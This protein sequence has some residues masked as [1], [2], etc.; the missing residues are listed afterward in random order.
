MVN[1]KI[2]SS[3]KYANGCHALVLKDISG[4]ELTLELV[5]SILSDWYSGSSSQ[6]RGKVAILKHIWYE[7]Y[8]VTKQSYSDIEWAVFSHK[9]PRN[10]KV[11]V[12][13]YLNDSDVLK[14]IGA[15]R[16]DRQRLFISFLAATGLRISEM[17][18]IRLNQTRNTYKGLEIVIQAEKTGITI[19]R[20]ITEDMARE[21]R[22]I[23]SGKEYLFETSN[24]KPYGREYVSAQ[25]K[26]I[27]RLAIGESISPHS[28]R[29]YWTRK[30]N[31]EGYNSFEIARMMGHK[32]AGSHVDNY[33][34]EVREA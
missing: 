8:G 24:G 9:T 17:T 31:N 28:F 1:L 30:K 7:K 22:S 4:R 10:A 16:S 21:I 14:I 29:H 23:F 20:V 26:K 19:T 34:H 27:G 12:P 3:R 33:L 25:I 11:K 13:H 6:Y 2:G 15:A 5:E 18:S 32:N